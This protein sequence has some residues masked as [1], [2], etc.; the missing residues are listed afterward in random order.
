[1][2][3]SLLCK[4]FLVAALLSP[5]SAIAQS[6]G[7]GG[8]AS[9]GG[10]SSGGSWP[11]ASATGASPNAGAAGAGTSAINSVTGPANAA[12]PKASNEPGTNSAGTA[13]SSGS[14][15]GAGGGPVGSRTV[16]TT[17]NPPEERQEVASTAPLLKGQRC[18]ATTRS[19]RKILRIPRSTKRSRVFAKDAEGVR[20][21]Q[22]VAVLLKRSST[23]IG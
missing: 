9:G 12:G 21:V 18:R 19:E 4:V 3:S 23:R 16:G 2:S 5:V 8:G 13:N 6:G 7:G 17:G 14:T 20:F 1:M 15:S 10:S 11:W 22:P